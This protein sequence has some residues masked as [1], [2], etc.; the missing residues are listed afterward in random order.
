MFVLN[1][2]PEK[3]L[4]QCFCHKYRTGRVIHRYHANKLVQRQLKR[5]DD[6]FE[7]DKLGKAGTTVVNRSR[8]A[9]TCIH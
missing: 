4:C 2:Q 1:T 6:V 3:Y 7:G 5:E 8:A 9:P